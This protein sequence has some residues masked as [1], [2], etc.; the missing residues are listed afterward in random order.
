MVPR[1][2]ERGKKKKKKRQIGAVCSAART[3]LTETHLTDGKS[4]LAMSSDT[5]NDSTKPKTKEFLF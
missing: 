3:G 4:W 5:G 1:A 2:S